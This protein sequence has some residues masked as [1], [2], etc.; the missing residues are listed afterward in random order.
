MCA[1]VGG[2]EVFACARVGDEA[3]GAGQVVR[4]KAVVVGHLGGIGEVGGLVA[5]E[6]LGAGCGGFPAVDALEQGRF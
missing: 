3:P 4:E 5:G 6:A 1:D 2:F